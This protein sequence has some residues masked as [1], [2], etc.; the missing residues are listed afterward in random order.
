MKIPDDERRERESATVAF[1]CG[2]LWLACLMAAAIVS[3]C[4]G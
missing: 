1:V 3:R 4:G 2:V